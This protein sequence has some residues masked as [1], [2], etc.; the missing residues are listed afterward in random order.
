M[1]G[2]TGLSGRVCVLELHDY[3][4]GNA[5]R[6]HLMMMMPELVQ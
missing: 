6:F 1:F 4:D 3:L 5:D 2:N